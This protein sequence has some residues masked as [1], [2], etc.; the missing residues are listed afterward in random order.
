M[1]TLVIPTQTTYHTEPIIIKPY[2]IK[3]KYINKYIRKDKRYEEDEI[4][5]D[6][7]GDSCGII[8]I[9]EL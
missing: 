5:L 8:H 4:N 9:Y 3:N 1:S 2:I 6:A 7:D